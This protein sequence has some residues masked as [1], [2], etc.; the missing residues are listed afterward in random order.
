MAYVTRLDA[1]ALNY[2]HDYWETIRDTGNALGISREAIGGLMAKEHQMYNTNIYYHTWS[3]GLALTVLPTH[4][5]IQQA[6]AIVQGLGIADSG[7]WRLKILHPVLMDVGPGNF[8]FTTAL[9]LLEQYN[10]V[11]EDVD[12][13]PLDLKKYNTDYRLLLTD[14]MKRSEP[15]TAI[16]YGLM[17]QEA[18]TFFTKTLNSVADQAYWNSLSPEFRDALRITYMNFGQT[19]MWEKYT[20]QLADYGFYRPEPGRLVDNAGGETYL[21]YNVDAVRGALGLPASGGVPLPLALAPGTPPVRGVLALEAARENFQRGLSEAAMDWFR[22]VRDPQ[23]AKFLEAVTGGIKA[24]FGVI[25]VAMQDMKGFP[26]LTEAIRTVVAGEIDG[27]A[28]LNLSQRGVWYLHSDDAQ[29]MSVTAGNETGDLM[30]GGALGDNLSGGG[31]QDVLFGGGAADILDGGAGD[32]VLIG[33][34][35][36]DELRGGADFDRYVVGRDRDTITDTDGRGTI[37]TAQ[38]RQI[39]GVFVQQADGSYAW[40]SDGTVHASKTGDTLTITL[41]G[42]AQVVVGNFQ[43]GQL[44]IQLLDA[45]TAPQ[46]TLTIV[47]DLTPIDADPETPGVQYSYDAL[48]NVVTDPNQPEPNRADVLNGRDIET[49]SDLI[50]SGGGDDILRGKAGDDQLEGGAGADWLSGDPGNDLLLGGADRDVLWG[51]PGNDRLYGDAEV[52]LETAIVQG[53]TDPPTGSQGEFLDGVVGD[54]ILVAGAADDVLLGGGGADLLVGGAGDDSLLGDLTSTSLTPGWTV[55][56]QVEQGPGGETLYVWS[57][58]GGSVE[59]DLDPADDTLY[60]GA[61]ADWIFGGPGTDLLDGGSG[62][63]VLFGEDGDDTLGGEPGMTPCAGRETK[64]SCRTRNCNS[65]RAHKPVVRFS[66]QSGLPGSGSRKS[67][68]TLRGGGSCRVHRTSAPKQAPTPLPLPAPH[69]HCSTP[70]AVQSS[71]RR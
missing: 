51:G 10:A 18:D 13:D 31:G 42:G 71:V 27:V 47:G 20:K 24:D 48:N 28:R 53:E 69:H 6:Y 32:D 44:G 52:A 12:D 16:F 22:R 15:T 60:G 59:P 14:L 5:Q 2:I 26:R 23:G 58:N 33:G 55:V 45:P 7:D 19:L 11:H 54:D 17:V 57:L 29:G 70:K 3:D 64:F 35:G 34:A 43:N 1:E 37:E 67:V 63:D 65:R 25:P 41:A 40:Q 4:A 56:R 36:D 21:Y 39:G 62:D 66:R 38:G 68:L 30:L 9:R 46:P 61:G 49:N 8:K 50:Q